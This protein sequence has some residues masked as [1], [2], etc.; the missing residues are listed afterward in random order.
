MKG[1]TIGGAKISKT[2]RL[3]CQYRQCYRQRC[4]AIIAE[5]QKRVNEKFGVDLEV[6]QRII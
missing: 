6:E 4:L 1:F 3:Y 5:A 2:Q